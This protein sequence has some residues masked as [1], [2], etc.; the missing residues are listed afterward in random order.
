MK[1]VKALTSKSIRLFPVVAKEDIVVSP[2]AMARGIENRYGFLQGPRS[3]A[4]YDLGP[5]VVFQGGM[6]AGKPIIE[7]LT[8][9]RDGVVCDVPDESSVAD[10]FIDDLVAWACAEHSLVP[11]PSERIIRAY[12]SVIDVQ[13]DVDVSR[14]F[15]GFAKLC[16][17]IVG[18]VRSYGQDCPDFQPAMFGFHGDITTLPSKAGPPGF[19]IERRDGEPYTSH[20]YFAKAPLRTADHVELLGQLESL[21]LSMIDD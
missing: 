13:M 11:P 8:I 15:P 16:Q 21:L 19:S 2:A 10:A 12:L 7:K 1:L 3:L 18:T 9:Y 20:R 14:A 4:E 6:F 17:Q 5:G